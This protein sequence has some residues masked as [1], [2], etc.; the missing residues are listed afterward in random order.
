MPRN[1]RLSDGCIPDGCILNSQV[2]FSLITPSRY[3]SNSA[4][5]GLWR[6]HSAFVFF[7]CSAYWRLQSF[8][9]HEPQ[10]LRFSVLSS[11]WGG[12]RFC[13]CEGLL[14][15]EVGIYGDVS[16]DM[17]FKH[18]WMEFESYKMITNIDI[19]LNIK[20]WRRSLLADILKGFIKSKKET[21]G[22]YLMHKMMH[23]IMKLVTKFNWY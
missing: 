13:S 2:S 11:T 21:Y 15:K 17:E 20:Y 1:A 14:C 4:Y 23:I 6:S 16:F 12:Q 18:I 8:W 7:F 19:I 3:G 22:S 5:F 10:G 9:T